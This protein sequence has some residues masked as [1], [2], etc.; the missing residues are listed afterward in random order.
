MT[1]NQ[2]Q[3]AALANLPQIREALAAADAEALQARQALVDSLAAVTKEAHPEIVRHLAIA[4]AALKQV[5][6]LKEKIKVL[7]QTEAEA[8]TAAN[9]LQVQLERKSAA[10]R[11]TL[12][13]TVDPILSKFHEWAANASCD[14]A[15]FGWRETVVATQGEVVKPVM[16]RERDRSL[17]ARRLANIA[18]AA[19]QWAI[20][21]LSEATP[22]AE[23]VAYTN[24]VS[25][26][27]V[28]GALA[29]GFHLRSFEQ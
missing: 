22:K 24:R 1:L 14:L 20:A 23:L 10:I 2:T 7:Q 11:G 8:R 26:E 16:Q 19:Q 18:T 29:I 9:R 3:L 17:E 25:S 6:E 21:Q 4:D 12:A 5:G 28:A 13:R 27:L 15:N